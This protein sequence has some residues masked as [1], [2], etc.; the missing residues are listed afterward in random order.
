MQPAERTRNVKY[1]IRDMAVL[2]KQ[3]EKEKKVIYLNIGDPNRFD[4]DAPPHLRK[5]VCDAIESRHNYYADSQGVREAVDAVV[6][7]SMKQGIE[8]DEN[9]VMLTLGASEAIGICIASLVNA[10]ENMLIPRPSYPVYSAYMNLFGCEKKFYT[11]DE[12]S[13]W[14]LDVGDIEGQIDEKTRAVVIINPNNPT[15]GV[16][17]RKTLKELVNLAGQHNLVIFAD[18][19]YDEL[20]LEGEM[21]H[22]AAF[23]G[24]VPVITFNGLAKN[25][26]VPGWRTGWLAITDR[27]QRLGDVRNAIMQLGRARLCGVTPQQFAV[28]PALE[29]SRK[30]LEEAREKL[31]RRRDITHKRINEISGLSLVN[32]RAAFYSFPRINFPMDDK[33]FAI[34]L[35]KEEGVAVVHGS[36][37]DMPGH[38]RLVYLPPE[39]VLEDAFDR[40]ERFVR[41]VNK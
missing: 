16:Y 33:D 6:Q 37:F 25:F 40:I 3:V 23:S 13:E 8:T 18:E 27:S 38:F 19:I 22:V 41:R 11:L 1:A 4:F 35:L 36:G 39:S 14:A 12:G 34:S 5:A 7:H 28:K 21:Q 31:K 24:E 2:A 17:D 15:G 20:I 32:P 29:G 30:H 9:S 10:G 26:L